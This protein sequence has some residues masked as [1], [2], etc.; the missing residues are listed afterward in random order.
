MN[1]LNRHRSGSI[2]NQLIWSF[3]LLLLLETLVFGFLSNYLFQRT[4]SETNKIYMN[5]FVSNLRDVTDTYVSYLEDM[6]EVVIKNPDIKSYLTEGGISA[7]QK[8]DVIEYLYS[9]KNTR[10]DIVSIILLNNRG[11]FLSDS[12]DDEF[13]FSG[14]FKQ[15]HWYHELISQ[16]DY[17]VYLT[18]SH[19]QNLI[20]GEF[21]WV[22]SLY[23]KV[24]QGFIVVDL[25]YSLIEELCS[26]INIGGRGYVFIVN[27]KNEMVYHPRLD[28]IYNGLKTERT[29]ELLSK[30][31]GTLDA[32]VDGRQVVYTFESS[33]I[34]GWTVVSVGFIDELYTGLEELRFF[35]WLILIVTMSVAILLSLLL[36]MQIT[37]PIE[38]L[39]SSMKEVE[40]GNFD[41]SINV[42]CDHEVYDL[43]RDC[44]IAIKK[45]R[46]LIKENKRDQETKR[47]HELKALQAQINPHFLYNTLDSIIW[48]TESNENEEAIAMTEQLASFFRLSLSRGDEIIP[49]KIVHDHIEAYLVI[50][51]MR[52]K[53]TLDYEIDFHPDTYR[54]AA[55]KLMIQPIVENS[56]YHGLKGRKN[57]GHIWISARI[58]GDVLLFRIEDDGVGMDQDLIA[59]INSGD[60]S[61]FSRSGVGLRNVA[62][63]IK[64]TFGPEYGLTLSARENGGLIVELTVPADYL[65]D[66]ETHG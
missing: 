66:E 28:L 4:L 17:D 35:L 49:V 61:H 55:L 50:Q 54:H 37:H 63:R 58:N 25:N 6:S 33:S 45:I 38:A 47:K 13:S 1:S 57:I 8:D 59:L 24:E 9:V 26:G 5:Q 7:K 42:K 41:I 40:Q 23:R 19:V 44:D 14:D 53:N 15:E 3:G 34:T 11:E 27:N 46:D 62:E 18:A 29:E 12:V 21:P 39:R 20:D 32:N 31:S 48:L 56:I 30:L 64:L 43:A 22:I 10:S 16:T 2:R 65:N 36:S 52:Y 60:Y 51:K